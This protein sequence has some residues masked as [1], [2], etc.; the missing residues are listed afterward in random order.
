MNLHIGLGATLLMLTGLA[1]ATEPNATG[2]GTDPGTGS[3]SGS[4]SGFGQSSVNGPDQNSKGAKAAR[5]NDGMVS[6][7]MPHSAA[8]QEK[9]Q[10]KRSSTMK[11]GSMDA[12][13][14]GAISQNEFT[15]YHNKMFKEM[16]KDGNGILSAS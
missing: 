13:H 16:D 12:D 6:K 9:D 14:D 7:E 2:T 3:I 1:L 8:Q 15:S 11:G 5:D 10:M 4:G